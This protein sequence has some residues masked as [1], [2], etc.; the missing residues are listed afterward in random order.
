MGLISKVI[1]KVIFS[2]V[3]EAESTNSQSCDVDVGHKDSQNC[4][5]GIGR[6]FGH[7]AVPVRK[8]FSA[9]WPGPNWSATASSTFSLSPISARPEM[10]EERLIRRPSQRMSEHQ[11]RNQS[12]S[13]SPRA[14]WSAC[15]KT[16]SSGIINK[17]V[18]TALVSFAFKI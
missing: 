3:S 17:L 12:R 7:L 11:A 1:P 15:T 5:K 14:F 18:P 6:N 4:F 16:R 13:Q 10:R 8:A 2:L 9:L